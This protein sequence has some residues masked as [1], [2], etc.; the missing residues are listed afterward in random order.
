MKSHVTWRVMNIIV[1]YFLAPRRRLMPG[2]KTRIESAYRA[3]PFANAL[4]L[5]PW[6]AGRPGVVRWLRVWLLVA[7][8]W[9][10]AFYG[11]WR[12]FL[13][14]E[15]PHRDVSHHLVGDTD[16]DDIDN[17]VTAS[18]GVQRLRRRRGEQ[19]LRQ[20]GSS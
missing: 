7:E 17:G 1:T 9:S 3:R 16:N 10:L 14:E 5:P 2:V 13:V 20:R 11:G 4:R 18:A 15:N 8:C 6:L 12:N 19:C